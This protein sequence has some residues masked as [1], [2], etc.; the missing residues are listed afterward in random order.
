MCVEQEMYSTN[1][2][3]SK[4]LMSK[5]NVDDGFIQSL[6]PYSIRVIGLSN[7]QTQAFVTSLTH[8]FRMSIVQIPSITNIN[9]EPIIIVFL[10]YNM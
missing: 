5:N 9:L 6:G 8:V 10:K 7:S 4:T 2:E 3:V 1:E